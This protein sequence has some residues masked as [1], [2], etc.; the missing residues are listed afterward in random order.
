M[1]DPRSTVICDFSAT[2]R[3]LNV[4]EVLF[5]TWRLGC[6]SEWMGRCRH[7]TC[8]LSASAITLDDLQRPGADKKEARRYRIC[9]RFRAARNPQK[10][11]SWLSRRGGAYVR[12]ER[13]KNI[14]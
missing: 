2:N 10:H 1:I 7:A 6:G 5:G 14:P 12:I 8:L 13:S 11:P 3:S 9:G 4:R